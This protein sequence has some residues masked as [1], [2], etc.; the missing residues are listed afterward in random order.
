MR[1]TRKQLKRLVEST[2][3]E[4]Q[5]GYRGEVWNLISTLSEIMSEYDAEIA[6]MHE[7]I[8]SASSSLSDDVKSRIDREA[9]RRFGISLFDILEGM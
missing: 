9:K 8:I 7:K 4:Q 6:D 1:I 5:T 3:R 2:I